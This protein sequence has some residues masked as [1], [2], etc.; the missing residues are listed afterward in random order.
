MI[1]FWRGNKSQYDT[2]KTTGY[3][4]NKLYFV[5]DVNNGSIYL[6]D[7]LIAEDS[8]DKILNLTNKVN[9]HLTWGQDA[10]IIPPGP[11]ED[12]SKVTKI[13]INSND[14]PVLMIN[15][16]YQTTGAVT[17][18]SW[19]DGTPDTEVTSDVNLYRH[20]YNTPDMIYTCSIYHDE[21][22]SFGS[23]DL[24]RSFFRIDNLGKVKAFKCEGAILLETIYPNIFEHNSHLTS[25]TRSFNSCTK[26]KT[27][28]TG[29]FNG[30]VNLTSVD[31]CFGGCKFT[32]L[33]DGLFDPCVNLTKLYR[34]FVG[35]TELTSISAN[36]IS[37]NTKLTAINGCF[38]GCTKL[39]N[40]GEGIFDNNTS[41]NNF[42]Q[43]FYDCSSIS[44]AYNCTSPG[45]PPIWKREP[46]PSVGAFAAGASQVF[47][48]SIP[49]NAG[50]TQIPT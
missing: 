38:N 20:E 13:S 18:I 34:T 21:N 31:E 26:L 4:A 25:L 47:R 12:L 44:H 5:T 29:M 1:K 40:I 22:F 39:S 37:K 23:L 30:M 49:M 32:S 43:C 36:L 14:N 6:G 2:I 16:S 19:G 10:D 3:D 35:C 33:P 45:L 41:I 11:V 15:L 24:G 50:G 48:D 17:K 42:D 7:K 46:I 27:L 28:P 9:D 8:Y